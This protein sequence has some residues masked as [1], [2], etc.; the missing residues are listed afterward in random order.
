MS[1]AVT[2]TVKFQKNSGITSK[3]WLAVRCHT[4]TPPTSHAV[5][6]IMQC[7]S[8]ILG[9]I[10]HWG[11]FPMKADLR[12]LKEPPWT[13]IDHFVPCSWEEYL[14]CVWVIHHE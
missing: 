13:E 11:I 14:Q 12:I 9:S 1:A 4:A 3:S 6:E 8:E 10:S 5:V 2:P 7:W